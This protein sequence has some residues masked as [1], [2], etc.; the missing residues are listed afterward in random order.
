MPTSSVSDK[1]CVEKLCY[2]EFGITPQ[3]VKCHRLGQSRPGRVQPL[4]IVLRTAEEA[5]FLIK[6]AKLLRQSRDPSVKSFVYINADLTKAEALTA[7]QRRCRRRELAVS[8]ISGQLTRATGGGD[9]TVIGTHTITVLNSRV[10]STEQSTADAAT[11]QMTRIQPLTVGNDLE[12]FGNSISE[13][14]NAV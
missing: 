13:T 2:T 3:V 10:P 8:R 14:D 1:S 5:E 12:N 6:N 9:N 11:S 7:Y 4:L